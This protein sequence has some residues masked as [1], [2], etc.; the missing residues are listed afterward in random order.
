MSVDE[1]CRLGS[2]NLDLFNTAAGKVSS[3][4][5]SE[6]KGNLNIWTLPT[7]EHEGVQLL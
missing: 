7:L 1:D 5:E 6:T 2:G 4:S 3:A